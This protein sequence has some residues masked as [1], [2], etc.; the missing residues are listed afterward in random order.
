MDRIIR[1]GFVSDFGMNNFQRKGVKSNSHAGKDFEEKIQL[2]LARKG[3][4]LEKNIKL[5]IGID[6]KKKKHAFDLGDSD[7]KIIVECKSH[8]WTE[9]GKVPSAKMTVWNEAMFYFSL[10]P[11]DYKKMFFVLR[12]YSK[13]RNKTLAEYYVGTY[14]HLIPK[15]VEIWEYTESTSDA[16][17]V[18][19]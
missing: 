5:N 3:I 1:H 16:F 14:E 15:G 17:K 12:D 11:I 18:F 2:Y 4:R 9:G 13:S 8:K 10:V 7:S 6:S 19:P